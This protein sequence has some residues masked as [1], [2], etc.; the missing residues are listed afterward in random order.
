MKQPIRST[1]EYSQYSKKPYIENKSE[2]FSPNMSTK[3][4]SYEEITLPLND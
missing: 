2:N 1:Y 4:L 3:S